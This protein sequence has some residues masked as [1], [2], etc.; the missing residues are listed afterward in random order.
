MFGEAARVCYQ[1][2]QKGGNAI[3]G[4]IA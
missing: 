4:A 3:A 2:G 1:R